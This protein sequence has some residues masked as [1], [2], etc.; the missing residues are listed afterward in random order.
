MA[1]PLYVETLVRCDADRLWHLTQAPD[2]HPRWD[3]RFSSIEPTGR[4][5]GGHQHFTYALILPHPR[6]ALLTVTGT[7][8]SVGERRD[9]AGRGTSALRF[10]PHGVLSPLGE[11]S[12]YW[13]YV[14]TEHGVRFLTGYDYVPG[15]GGLGR[16]LDPLLVR[17][18]VGWATAWSFDRLRL[19]AETGLD[20]ALARNRALR[21]AAVRSVGLGLALGAVAAAGGRRTRR[22]GR[23]HGQRWVLVG[24]AATGVAAATAVAAALLWPVGLGTPSARRCLRRAPDRGSGTAPASLDTVPS[25]R[26]RHAAGQAAGGRDAAGQ[27]AAGQAAAGGEA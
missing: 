20:P 5:A 27:D 19:W 22:H 12:G 1:R 9:A 6:A 4:D 8:V 26:A 24:A 13:R 16:V 15:W 11:G 10:R 17:P 25:P 2:L 14:P 3:L 18:L 23:R 7:G 21:D